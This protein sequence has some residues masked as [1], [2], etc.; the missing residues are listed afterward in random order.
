MFPGVLPKDKGFIVKQ[1]NQTRQ[2]KK[3][4]K[5]TTKKSPS[6]ASDLS[7]Q[8]TSVNVLPE[9][10]EVRAKNYTFTL[11]SVAVW[12]DFND[13]D[14]KEKNIRKPEVK[15]SKGQGNK[16][17]LIN[18]AFY[19]DRDLGTTMKR[20]GAQKKEGSFVH[21]SEFHLNSSTV[22]PFSKASVRLQPLRNA[23]VPN[24]DEH[25][26]DH[27]IPSPGR[28]KTKLFLPEKS[29]TIDKIH[30]DKQSSMSL[31]EHREKT[32]LLSKPAFVLEENYRSDGELD[33]MEVVEKEIA[34]PVTEK[35]AFPQID[36]ATCKRERSLDVITTRVVES[37]DELPASKTSL[38]LIR[39]ST[40]E[41]K[42]HGS[43]TLNIVKSKQNTTA[44][45]PVFKLSR[46]VRRTARYSI[47]S[48]SVARKRS[49]SGE[50]R[51]NDKLIDRKRSLKTTDN[52]QKKIAP[53]HEFIVASS[54]TKA[55]TQTLNKKRNSTDRKIGLKFKDK[56]DP[57]AKSA[58][59]QIDE[60]KSTKDITITSDASQIESES[61]SEKES[62]I[63]SQETEA[64]FEEE[65]MEISEEIGPQVSPLLSSSVVQGIERGPSR[66][67]LRSAKVLE[68]PLQLMSKNRKEFIQRKREEFRR[69][70]IDGDGHLSMFELLKCFPSALTRQQV[71]YLKM[72]YQKACNSTF[73]G[74]EEYLCVDEM[75][76][77]MLEI[78]DPLKSV[79][80]QVDLKRVEEELDAYLLKFAEA[81]AT[82]PAVI[83]A[84]L[85]LQKCLDKF[86]WS[87]KR[88][89]KKISELHKDSTLSFGKADFLLLIPVFVAEG[90]GSKDLFT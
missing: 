11:P 19:Q 51:K 86:G 56:Q 46:D 83:K 34:K 23:P 59:L 90:V 50:K 69:I 6:V 57:A 37:K 16:T 72:I 54:K 73:F 71:D 84:N 45:L 8:S 76:E 63:C 81:Y 41:K 35:T 15:K 60:N 88:I 27:I 28:E 14:I 78:G 58:A 9:R 75:C 77:T 68:Y 85:G 2:G 47:K 21:P 87:L 7:S 55:G 66:I 40:N 22:L 70:D 53:K 31:P 52:S 80:S 64:F 33:D 65:A 26:D 62:G 67:R 12:E 89:T 3:K 4:E 30:I 82:D 1:Q 13:L 79:Y 29:M 61:S 32:E 43:E 49:S 20:N 36:L 5:Q 17:D 10:V 39:N 38:P 42:T 24:V 74:L 44:A 25:R 48:R 18:L